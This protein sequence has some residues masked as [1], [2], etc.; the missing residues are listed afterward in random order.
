MSYR[1]A[2]ESTDSSAKSSLP[3]CLTPES[4]ESLLKDVFDLLEG[5]APAWYTEELHN[6][7]AAVLQEAVR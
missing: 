5:Y 3:G 2:E 4:A 1:Q 6:R 7:A